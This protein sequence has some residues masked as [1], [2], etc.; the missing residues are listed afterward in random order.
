MAAAPTGAALW[1]PSGVLPA[2][3][4]CP[5]RSPRAWRSTVQCL[6][7]RK[8]PLGNQLDPTPFFI[9]LKREMCGP[10]NSVLIVLDESISS[11]LWQ[12]GIAFIS[13]YLIFHSNLISSSPLNVL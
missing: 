6:Y 12:R 9:A 13:D 1:A 4:D 8:T 11:A 3:H 2:K 5:V 10:D 7:P